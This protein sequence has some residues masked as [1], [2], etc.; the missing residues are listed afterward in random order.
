MKKFFL[1]LLLLFFILLLTFPYGV[2]A[3]SAK[4][5]VETKVEGENTKVYQSVEATVNGKTVKK[6]SNQPGRIEVEIRNEGEKK[7]GSTQSFLE[8][9]GDFSS[10]PIVSSSSEPS[11]SLSPGISEDESFFQDLLDFVKKSFGEFLSKLTAL[12]K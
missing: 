11:P 7:S 6:E 10:S 3:S 5:V 12:L 1:S 9:K 2:F 8:E 4:S